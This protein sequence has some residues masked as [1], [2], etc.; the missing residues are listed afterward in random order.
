MKDEQLSPV[1]AQQ[2]KMIV[3][4]MKRRKMPLNESVSPDARSLHNKAV[5]IAADALK[6]VD[7]IWGKSNSKNVGRALESLKNHLTDWMKGYKNMSI[8]ESALYEGSTEN[9]AKTLDAIIGFLSKGTNATGDKIMKMGKGIKDHYKKEGSFSPDQAKW[10]FNTSNALFKE[11]VLNEITDAEAE[12][13]F[14]YSDLQGK[15]HKKAFKTR[16][17]FDRWATKNEAKIKIID[18]LKDRD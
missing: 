12:V 6:K 8:D 13:V 14:T 5:K 1:A 3:K 17:S 11:S 10:I 9:A 2:F 4:V 15:K 18:F 16:K 7:G